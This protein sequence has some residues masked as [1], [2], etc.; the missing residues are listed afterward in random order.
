MTYR[1]THIISPIPR[2]KRR[3]HIRIILKAPIILGKSF[4]ENIYQIEVK[5]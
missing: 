3:W 2:R 5:I 4:T 1:M